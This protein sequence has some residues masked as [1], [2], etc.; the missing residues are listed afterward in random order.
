M[1]TTTD[2]IITLTQGTVSFPYTFFGE[3]AMGQCMTLA[4][5]YTELTGLFFTCVIQMVM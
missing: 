5:R 4:D 1:N 2:L 3:E